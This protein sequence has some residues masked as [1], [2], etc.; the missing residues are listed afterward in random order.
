MK[1]FALQY[2]PAVGM[3]KEADGNFLLICTHGILKYNNVKSEFADA[4][5]DLSALD[6]NV[7]I[8]RALRDSNGNLYIGTL[9][10]GLWVIPKGQL[11]MRPYEAKSL[12]FDLN[13]ANVNDI[14]ED[15]NHNLWVGCYKKGLLQLGRRPAVFHTWSLA[16]QGYKLGSGVSSVALGNDGDAWCIVQKA[17]VYHLDAEGKVISRQPAPDGSNVIYRDYH[18]S[19]WLGTETALYSYQPITGTATHILDMDGWGVNCIVD[20]NDGTLFVSNFGKGLTIYNQS[21]R[22]GR[23]VMYES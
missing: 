12:P 21:T 18:G 10:K 22:E 11:A 9:G 16:E 20:N 2:G 8:H 17:G 13:S 4:G 6:R 3:I 5:Y 1:N 15:K 7:S 19:Y 23:S 14:F